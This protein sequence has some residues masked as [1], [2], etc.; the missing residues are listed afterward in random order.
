[1]LKKST[2]LF[3]QHF[4]HIQLAGCAVLLALGLTEVL[5]SLMGYAL[6]GFIPQDYLVVGLLVA[7]LVSL[8]VVPLLI[9]VLEQQKESLMRLEL[10]EQNRLLLREKQLSDGII[11]SPIAMFY[12]LDTAGN[13]VR[14]NDRLVEVSGYSAAQLT[15]MNALNFFAVADQP[16][17]LASVQRT[18]A[19]GQSTNET[20]F[21]TQSGESIPYSF[22]S[23]LVTIDG[24][25][26]KVGFGMDIRARKQTE[27]ALQESEA[28][29]K[30]ALEGGGDCV[31]EWNLA[32]QQILLSPQG[33]QMFGFAEH[34]IGSDIQSW[35]DRVHRDDRASL[36]RDT[37]SYL[38]GGL[39][40][41]SSEYRVR[42][43]A[44]D[45]KWVH[46]RGMAVRHDAA[47]KVLSM[48]G[49][50]TDINE[51]KLA[52]ATIEY[53]ANFDPLTRLPN[54]RLFRDRLEQ[55]IKNA[56]RV[57]LPIAL[58]LIDLDHFKEV[59]DTLGHDVG[60]ILLIEAARRIQSCVRDSDTVA[61]LGGDEFIVILSDLASPSSV[62]SVAQHI[63]DQLA[64]SF[65]L[66]SETV[67]V[68]ASIGIT[69]YPADTA[70]IESLLKH[71]DQALYVAK[72]AGRN[73]F[74]Y[75]TPALQEAAQRRMHWIQ[76]LRNAVDQQQFLVHYQPIVQLSNGRIHKAEALVR[77]QHPQRGL[78]SPLEFIALAEESRLIVELGDWVFK[79]A[80]QQVKQWR[81]EYQ[82]DFQ[83]SVNRSPAQFTHTVNR[84]GLW[85]DYLH[86]IGLDAH[87]MVIEITEGLLLDTENHVQ[88]KLLA[89]RQ[90]G[91]QIALDDFGT[92][93][94]SLSYL[95]KFDIDYLKIDRSFVSNLTTHS[96]DRAVCE[97]I[98]VMAHKL[99]LQVIAEGVETAAQR[100]WLTQA[101]CD[102]AQ[103][104]LFSK[105]VTA[106]AFEGLLQRVE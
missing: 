66:H 95:K 16:S 93:Y 84:Q 89:F 9:F 37:R 50:Y 103:G 22:A 74:R 2:L 60:D 70:D 98:I 90:A 75:F 105:P 104:Y 59:N 52:A 72:D 81:A 3:F 24:T 61:R 47:G 51:R 4:S 68:S 15:G 62:D 20:Y 64:E 35:Q 12:M 42:C 26:F 34:E 54:R 43:K 27:L 25:P 36:E 82:P 76:D 67:F 38:A 7:I 88:N 106:Q 91:M 53:Q 17:V 44:G 11:N 21:L 29:W 73:R 1:M 40:Y 101:G 30:F 65:V 58:M 19:L 92:G 46:A 33:K 39:T 49:V 56:H 32:T 78:V 69:L 96:D 10:A 97:A 18:F 48:F 57:G 6:Y 99:G 41:F 100:D 8:L 45:W 79:Q 71:A 63:L 87:S 94:S 5:V 77:W 14:W 102:Y 28:R 86:E 13:L 23:R 80:A 83:I 55:Q 85:L 31:W